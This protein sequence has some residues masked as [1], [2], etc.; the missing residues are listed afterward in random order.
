MAGTL[1]G[2][3]WYV[4]VGTGNDDIDGHLNSNGTNVTT[5]YD[6]LPSTGPGFSSNGSDLSIGLDLPDDLYFVVNSDGLSISVNRASTGALLDTLQIGNFNGSSA[7]Q[8]IVNSLVVDPNSHTVYVGRWGVTKAESGIVAVSYT[9][10]GVLDHNQTYNASQTRLVNGNEAGGITDVRYMD[11]SNN[12]QI[13]YYTDNDN[14][15][16]T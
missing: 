3:L 16:T 11:L 5:A 12:N 1:D 15:Y 8:D 2:Q 7:A 13:L 10:A 6:N 4:V 14:H 9:A